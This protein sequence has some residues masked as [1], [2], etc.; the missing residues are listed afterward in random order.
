MILLSWTSHASFFPICQ[1]EAKQSRILS[2]RNAEWEML[3]PWWCRNLNAHFYW[4]QSLQIW[5]KFV[6]SF[7]FPI[8]MHTKMS[9]TSILM[10]IVD[11]SEQLAV[12]VCLFF[13]KNV[14]VDI[15]LVPF[16]LTTCC[17]SGVACCES[18]CIPGGMICRQP[19]TGSVQQWSVLFPLPLFE[20]LYC[21]WSVITAGLCLYRHPGTIDLCRHPEGPSL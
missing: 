14:N 19:L 7:L 18:T 4:I 11:G 10:S 6:H 13:H 16:S 9:Q 1:T 17:D 21:V 3:H 20:S 5:G 12:G 8:Y 15:G 2:Q